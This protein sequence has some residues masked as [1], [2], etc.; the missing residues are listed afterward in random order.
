M[1]RADG[2]CRARRDLVEMP[3][4]KEEILNYHAT[5]DFQSRRGFIRLV[6]A[7]G[8]RVIKTTSAPEFVVLI[9]MIH[10]KAKGTLR[11]PS[12]D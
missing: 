1:A 4:Q 7:E 3:R 5:W 12:G 10:E 11:F 8:Q 9:T 2:A 6:T